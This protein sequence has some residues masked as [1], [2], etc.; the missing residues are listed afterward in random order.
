[1][2][3]GVLVAFR[4]WPDTCCC[5]HAMLPIF[6]QLLFL[7]PSRSKSTIVMLSCVGAR[8][9]LACS[10]RARGDHGRGC[11]RVCQLGLIRKCSD[12]NSGNC[13]AY[14]IYDMT[15]LCIR[16]Q[17]HV[18]Y[19]HTV[20]RYCSCSSVERV[21]KEQVLA[22]SLLRFRSGGQTNKTRV[23]VPRYCITHAYKL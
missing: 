20:S 13:H 19:L 6:G 14:M 16:Y 1:M 9:G 17:E 12:P 5:F 10:L 22:K 23:L 18:L 8:G 3:R 11:P 21:C 7:T 2:C 15:L 4:D